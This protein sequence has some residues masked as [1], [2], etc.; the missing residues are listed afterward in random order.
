MLFMYD[1]V[2]IQI[3]FKMKKKIKEIL[4]RS[5]PENLP[6]FSSKLEND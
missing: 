2:M 1:N 6:L 3:K 5:P 4:T